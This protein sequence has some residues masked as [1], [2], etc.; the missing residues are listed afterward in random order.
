MTIRQINKT[1]SGF[2]LYHFLLISILALFKVGIVLKRF[3][4]FL[5][6]ILRYIKFTIHVSYFFRQILIMYIFKDQINKVILIQKSL[7]NGRY[8]FHFL[9]L[10]LWGVNFLLGLVSCLSVLC[11]YLVSHS[12]NRE[13]INPLLVFQS[14]GKAPETQIW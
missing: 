2:S 11:V 6:I 12:T 14:V 7:T 1:S 13:W 5:T 3:L 4:V 9:S 8:Y 10:P